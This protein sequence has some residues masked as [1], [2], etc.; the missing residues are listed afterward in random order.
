MGKYLD[1]RA[2]LETKIAEIDSVAEVRTIR[3]YANYSFPTA[4]IIPGTNRSEVSDAAND[5]RTYS[6]DIFVCDEQRT[7]PRQ[8][9]EDK[10]LEIYDQLLEMLD[11]IPVSDFSGEAFTRVSAGGFGVDEIEGNQV[12][13]GKC[14]FEIKIKAPKGS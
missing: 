11:Q 2:T 12:R 14:V 5:F 10:I 1:F 3:D 9:I 13:F 4:F 7:E 8:D 6:F